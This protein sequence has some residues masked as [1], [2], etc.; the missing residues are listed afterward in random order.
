VIGHDKER[1]TAMNRRTLLGAA[2]ALAVTGA[3]AAIAQQVTRPNPGAPGQWR[4]IGTAHARHSVDHDTI[5]V[6]GPHD[7][8]RAI[9]FKVTGAPLNMH[10][11]VVTYEN[12]EPDRLDVRHDIPQ[13]GETRTIDLRGA[14]QRRIRKIE[15]WYD[16]KGLGNRKAAVTAFGM[17]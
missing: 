2:L 3:T 8:F 5:V 12:G 13:G 17:K 1:Q 10:R 14:G 6:A 7:N 9:K 4:L 16:T 11:I 15:F